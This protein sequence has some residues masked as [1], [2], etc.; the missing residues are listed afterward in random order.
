VVYGVIYKFRCVLKTSKVRRHVDYIKVS[1]LLKTV[2]SLGGSWF[3][4]FAKKKCT[5]KMLK[6]CSMNW[7]E[8]NPFHAY[9]I[10]CLQVK[11]KFSSRGT[12]R[13]QRVSTVVILS[14]WRADEHLSLFLFVLVGNVVS[15]P[16]CRP[17]GGRLL[18]SKFIILTRKWND[19]YGITLA[20]LK[21]TNTWT[22]SVIIVKLCV[23]W[24][25]NTPS[26]LPWRGETCVCIFTLPYYFLLSLLSL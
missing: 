23:C 12:R 1:N 11:I 16:L 21:G 26:I 6:T 7:G 5:M 20:I 10:I 4:N 9:Y 8:V 17:I 22:R 2:V 15:N 14:T 18:G 3:R 25:I 13:R 24:P 19:I